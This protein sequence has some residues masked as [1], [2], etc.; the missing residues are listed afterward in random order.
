MLLVNHKKAVIKPNL[1]F[2]EHSSQIILLKDLFLFLLLNN[3]CDNILEEIRFIFEIINK[4]ITNK[5][6]EIVSSL[7]LKI[8]FN[9][10][11]NCYYFVY[12]LFD[13]ILIKKGFIEFLNT[14]AFN[15]VLGNSHLFDFQKDHNIRTLIENF[16]QS[17]S[18]S[19]L[20]TNKSENL[21]VLFQPDT[22]SKSNFPNAF[23]FTAFRKQRDQFYNLFK[24][25]ND[26]LWF[27]KIAHEKKIQNL[28][29]NN[30]RTMFSFSKDVGNS[31][32]LARLFV[33]QL[34]KASNCEMFESKKSNKFV[35]TQNEVEQ[36]S[37]TEDKFKKLHNRF[38][39]KAP[40]GLSVAENLFDD[41]FNQNEKFFRDFIYFADSYSF[42]EQLKLILKSKL[43]ELTTS[44]I[45]FNENIIQNELTENFVIHIT[46][47]NLLAKILGFVCF[48]NLETTRYDSPKK[49]IDFF[50]QQKSL[51]FDTGF[52]A[53]ILDIETYLV[54]SLQNHVLIVAI[55]W[56][57][58]FL[59]FVDQITLTIDYFDDVLTILILVYKYYLPTLTNNSTTRQTFLNRMFIQ[60][61]LEK[62]FFI[63]KFSFQDRM[64]KILNNKPK[65]DFFH[66]LKEKLQNVDHHFDSNNLDFNTEMVNA[67]VIAHFFP[68]FSK[69]V[70]EVF[71]QAPNEFR[72]ITPTCVS[73]KQDTGFIS[74][75]KKVQMQNR[76]EDMFLNIHSSSMKKCIQFLSDQLA[77]TCIKHIKLNLYLCLKR[78]FFD[79]YLNSD[80]ELSYEDLIKQ[81]DLIVNITKSIRNECK[82]SVKEIS[83]NKVKTIFPLI[84]HEQWDTSVINF[85]I[86][87][88]LRNIELRSSNWIDLNITD[89]VIKTDL[90]SYIR[91][92]NVNNKKS[93]VVSHDF[94]T[95][96]HNRLFSNT[97]Y[98]LRESLL[99]LINQNHKEMDNSSVKTLLDSAHIARQ[100]NHLH[101]SNSKFF[102]LIVLDLSMSIIT[103]KPELLDEDLFDCFIDFWV[104]NKVTYNRLICVKF[105]YLLNKTESPQMTWLK[106]EFL[107]KRMLKDKIIQFTDIEEGTLSVLK[108][109]WHSSMLNRFASLLKS[110]VDY[111]QSQQIICEDNQTISPEIVDWLSWI[112]V[113][114]NFP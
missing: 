111:V 79:D 82:N 14:T 80:P 24:C 92:N 70:V 108:C 37:I 5:A 64:S 71:K 7:T 32:H 58:H 77:V 35:S 102:D 57:V 107:L 30:L 34:Q 25:Y 55:P 113:E 48:Y 46:N 33:D 63:K 76:I 110:L 27:L 99:N 90:C 44:D 47:L 45:L 41:H 112:C 43:I 73:I 9:N 20:S 66:Q 18:V 40:C 17:K 104:K 31:Y 61:Y 21:F 109:D 65:N 51:R 81:M 74:T 85:A 69:M 87:L 49:H 59:F 3:F 60:L 100:T 2:V 52:Q 19:L 67:D 22:D 75:S 38:V 88:C 96:E 91:E 39:N 29:E 86:K 97:V 8:I 94:N 10:Y 78:K 95:N 89:E 83:T 103:F 11:H 62:L 42:N 12:M 98:D 13:D 68:I 72:K 16:K 36:I 50:K 4:R 106:Y 56:V 26:N 1:E 101:S 54:N 105:F 53:P 23:S 6:Q 93:V 15:Y 84:V 28:F 114:D